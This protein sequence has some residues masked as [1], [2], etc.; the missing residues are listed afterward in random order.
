MKKVLLRA[1]LLTN[2]GYGVHSRQVFKWLYERDD[3]ELH[4]EVLHWGLC[5]WIVN[6]DYE[7]GLI[8]AIM[9]RTAPQQNNDY[10]ISFQVQLPD[11][12]DTSLAKKNVGVTAVVETDICN[13]QWVN[14]VNEMDHIIVPS[15]F[16]KSVLENTASFVRIVTPVTVIPE[17]FNQSIINKKELQ[18]CYDERYNFSTKN[19]FLVVGTL[20]SGNADDDR[21]NLVNTLVWSLESLKG[22]KDVGIIIKA[23][24]GKSTS[25]DRNTT[26]KVISQIVDNFREGEYPKVHLIH[27]SMSNKE[28]A[29][30]FVDKTIK[31]YI[32]ATRGEGYG[33]P[34]VDAAAAGVPV[35][36]TNW[37]GHLDFLEN[38]FLK[39]DYKMK[40]IKESRIDNR[41]FVENASWAEPEK[42]SFQENLEKLCD[43]RE[44]WLK[45]ALELKKKVRKKFSEER[46]KSLYD[47]VLIE[48]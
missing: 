32:T 21:K 8:G 47:K 25:A 30:L 7:D 15:N 44:Y 6:P 33:L 42:E 26:K 2:S 39:V 48:I 31:G 1:P 35:I 29:A 36:A 3:I 41:I 16:T 12:W 13:L 43:N 4:C 19:N 45:K 40:K 27:G 46:I 9:E 24:V 20:T 18:D 38:K 14:K 34:L 28:I 10:D 5:S 23:S 17:W 37:S 11:E 22:Q